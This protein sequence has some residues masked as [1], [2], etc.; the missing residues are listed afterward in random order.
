MSFLETLKNITDTHPI[1]NKEELSKELREEKI[2]HEVEEIKILVLAAAKDGY[3]HVNVGD[4][5]T[6]EACSKFIETTAKPYIPEFNISYSKIGDM[7][8]YRKIFSW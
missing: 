7:P 6:D 3:R 1:R 2:L 8:P 4:Y 5:Y